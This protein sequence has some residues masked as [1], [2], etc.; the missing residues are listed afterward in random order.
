MLVFY[1][2]HGRRGDRLEGPMTRSIRRRRARLRIRNPRRA[3]PGHEPTNENESGRAAAPFMS[4]ARIQRRDQAFNPAPGFSSHSFHR[5]ASPA[6]GRR[7]PSQKAKTH[8][9][10]MKGD[11]ARQSI[12]HFTFL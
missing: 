6:H 11:P 5:D 12:Y 3:R 1:R 7:G 8:K 10:K 4:G 2:G 9:L